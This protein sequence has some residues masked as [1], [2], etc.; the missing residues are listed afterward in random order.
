MGGC[1]ASCDLGRAWGQRGGG[2]PAA[3]RGEAASCVTVI[4]RW[5]SGTAAVPSASSAGTICPAASPPSTMPFR[6]DFP[7]TSSYPA[8]SRAT[9]QRTRSGVAHGVCFLPAGVVSILTRERPW[10]IRLSSHGVEPSL[11]PGRSRDSTHFNCLQSDFAQS[12]LYLSP[13]KGLGGHSQE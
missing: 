6:C 5:G 2:P 11:W 9:S 4:M 13:M 10:L 3:F 12:P 1:R 7:T 8:C